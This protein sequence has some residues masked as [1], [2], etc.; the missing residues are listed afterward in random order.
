MTHTWLR[1]KTPQAVAGLLEE[2]IMAR[3]TRWV[4]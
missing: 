3:I 1:T 4:A 2:D